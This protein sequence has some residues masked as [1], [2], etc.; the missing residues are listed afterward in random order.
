MKRLLALAL[1]VPWTL[2]AILPLPYSTDPPP[3]ESE[4]G[5]VTTVDPSTIPGYSELFSKSQ[6]RAME[7]PTFI[8]R[9]TALG[10]EGERTF[11]VPDALRKRVDFWKKIYTV[12]TGSQAVLHDSEDLDVVYG[13]VDLSPITS[14]SRLNKRARRRAIARYLKEERRKLERKLRDLHAKQSSPKEI[15]L[16]SFA[17]FR[18]FEHN[19]DPNRF[20][21]AAKNL[22]T[23]VGQREKIVQ[24]FLF[25]GRYW[26]RMMQIFEE[27]GIP[28]ELTRLPLVESAFDLSARSKVGASGVWQFMRSTGKRYLRIDRA[29]DERNDPITATYA[30]AE[31]LRHNFETLERWPLAITAYNHGREGM[32]R[33]VQKLE[34]RELADIIAR[35]ESPT[36]GF[37]SSNFYSEFLAI[38]EVEREYRKHF[39]ALLVDAP[40]EYEEVR[41][42]EAIAFK[43]LA[44]K[45]GVQQD[46]LA[47]L[48]PA[49]TSLLLLSRLPIPAT[50]P[51]K[52]PNGSRQVCGFGDSE[53]QAAEVQT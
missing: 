30:A 15:P 7:L 16:E 31:L 52:M 4:P 46:E 51:V 19:T 48:N 38:L 33:A 11:E 10:Y 40:V 8:S 44:E 14:N 39:G 13:V 1:V 22:R 6:L 43:A 32:S 21:K 3:E 17:L 47:L 50:Y 45:C 49:F 20:L 35:Y 27:R 9:S 25:G 37:A 23:Q 28:K 36:F 26:N 41:V 12:Y 53:P 18:K 5:D 34:T 42:P 29:I 2:F 24:G